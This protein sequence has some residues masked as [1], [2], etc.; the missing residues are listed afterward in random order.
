ML[1]RN[2][3]GSVLLCVL[4]VMMG[5]AKPVAGEEA[6]PEAV[7]IGLALPTQ[8][9]ERWKR[10]RDHMEKR[11]KEMGIELIVQVSANDQNE[12]HFNTEQLTTMGIKALIIAP[13]DS[14]GATPMVALA[15]KA[16]IKVISYDRL[17][18]NADVDLYV[19][20]DNVKIGRMQ[21]RY[22]IE[23]APRGNY[24]LLG[25][26]IYDSNARFYKEGAMEVLQPHIDSGAISVVSDHDVIDWEPTE[27]TKIVDNA[28]GKM[29]NNIVAILAPNDAMAGGAIL[30]LK[31]NNVAGK[32]FVTGQDGDTG[33]GKRIA[34]GE[35]SMTVFK[36]VEKEA[37]TALHA[38]YLMATGKDF[39]AL[40]NGRTVNNGFG[41][42]PAIILEPVLVDQKNVQAVLFDSGYI[43]SE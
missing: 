30:S 43:E 9:Q 40:A 16:G 20:Y 29:N 12:Q 32:V 41:D 27:V 42:I 28:L 2:L 17:I 15:H 26:P 31:Q 37:E 18:M 34:S 10:D 24:I 5:I 19:S 35:Q 3:T 4:A 7:R 13:H 39:V 6:R 21:G 33:V 22:L 36:D 1:M 23:R 25:G 8:A 38:A 11:A 14:E